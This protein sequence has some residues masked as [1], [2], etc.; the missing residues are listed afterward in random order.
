MSGTLSLHDIEFKNFKKGLKMDFKSTLMISGKNCLLGRY[1]CLWCQKL[2]PWCL[3]GFTPSKTRWVGLFYAELHWWYLSYIINNNW[4]SWVLHFNYF[5]S[6]LFYIFKEWEI[7]LFEASWLFQ[8]PT[9]ELYIIVLVSL[10]K[11]Y[12]ASCRWE[13]KSWNTRTTKAKEIVL[14]HF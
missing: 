10:V 6:F 7:M 12:Q 13:Q 2:P 14:N 4:L 3:G 11:Y 1:Y 9:K 8:R 5:C